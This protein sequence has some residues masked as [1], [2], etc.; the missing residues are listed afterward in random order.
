V[1]AVG[2]IQDKAFHCPWEFGGHDTYF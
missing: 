1:E 2:E